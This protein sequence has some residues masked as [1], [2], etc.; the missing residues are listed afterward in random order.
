MDAKIT[1]SFRA[2]VIQK[3]KEYA[4]KQGTSLSRLTENL[5]SRLIREDAQHYDQFQISD[6]VFMAA[7]GPTE[8]HSKIKSNKKLRKEYHESH[9]KKS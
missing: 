2:D 9:L 8:Y 6:W 7:D 5:L 3:A 4:E 1:L